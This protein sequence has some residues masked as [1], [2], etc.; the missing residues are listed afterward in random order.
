[1]EKSYI[2]NIF[3][4]LHNMPEIGF[5]EFK[6]AAFIENELQNNGFTVERITDTGLKA[7]FNTNI[8]GPSFAVRADIDALS[9]YNENG[10][11]FFLH[12]C[13][14]DAHTAIVI[15]AGI[16]ALKK[17][18]K[19]GRL[20]LLFQPAEET[21]HGAFNLINTGKINDIDELVGFHL[22]PYE[23]LRLGHA[24][25]ALQ[26]GGGHTLN[27][28][29]KA[30]ATHAARPHLGISSIE[31]AIL[32]SNAVNSLHMNPS[33]PHSIKLTQFKSQGDAD[34]T[35]PEITKLC[36]DT[37]AADNETLEELVKKTKHAIH[38]AVNSI[39]ATAEIEEFGTPAAAYDKELM[40]LV[41][42]SITEV[43]GS[44]SEPLQTNGCDDFHHYTKELKIKTAFI[45]IGADL[46]PGLHSPDMSF[47]HKALIYGRD[48]IAKLI[49]KRL[50]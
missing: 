7:V 30:V 20:I 23:E 34:N 1:M 11:E 50:S 8:P 37:R 19:K 10:E 33:I 35:I 22:R 46:K 4:Q 45:G 49:L 18:I 24:T 2:E 31:A 3:E 21:G 13:A 16:A 26:H 29:V 41:K 39:G 47:D 6:T 40:E 32:A 48:I 28:T 25:P 15:S 9:F 44:C 38:T 43:L 42:K 17:G 14:H 36:F 12:A 5:N 27:V